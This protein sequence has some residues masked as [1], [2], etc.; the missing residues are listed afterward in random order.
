LRCQFGRKTALFTTALRHLTF[1]P[2]QE[3]KWLALFTELKTVIKL[4]RP[5]VQQVMAGFAAQMLGVLY[6][7]QQAGLAGDDQALLI[8]QRAITNMQVELER[9]LNA[10]AL[11]RELNVSYS[12]F[13]H[14]FLQHTG[15]SPHQY[16]LELRLV[17][18]RN[19]LRQTSQSVKE[20]AQQAGFDDEHYFCRFFKM[21]TGLTPG[22]WR[23]RS[24]PDRNS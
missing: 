21:K 3:E 18:A 14:T 4:N 5:A 16:L 24:L 19:L 20:I 22:Q 2:G 7:G 11:A 9:G 12:T 1:K 8:V 13:R 10:Q 23:S 15:S 6:S 17:R